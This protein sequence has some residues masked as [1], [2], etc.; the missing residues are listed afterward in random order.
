MILRKSL[1]G[2]VSL[3]VFGLV[4]GGIVPVPSAYAAPYRFVSL[5][6]PPYEYVENGKIKGIAVEILEET[7]RLMNKKLEIEI[8]PW[9]RSIEMFQNGAADGIF[10]FFKTPEREK[11]TFYSNEIVLH[12]KMLLWVRRDSDIVFD[13]NLASLGKY[14]VGIVRKTSYGSKMD[15]A[16]KSHKLNV[17]ES[18][19][20]DETI[21]LL[22]NRRIDIWVSNYFGAVFELNKHNL[23]DQVKE[24]GPPIEIIP[25]YIGF[26]KKRNLESLR[27]EFDRAFR[28][29]KKSGKYEEILNRYG[30]LEVHLP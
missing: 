26:S 4:A 11:F 20:I 2:I 9:A 19:T 14:R 30:N 6:Y 27:N 5:N 22:L 18:Y 10:T 21:N 25:T 7:F 12:Q 29:L 13:G 28:K 17:Y 15:A 8:Y 16:I 23:Q 1:W 3:L 24:L